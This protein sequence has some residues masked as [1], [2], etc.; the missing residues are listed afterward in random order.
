MPKGKR[1]LVSFFRF[2]CNFPAVWP[3]DLAS[4]LPVSQA[5]R[6]TLLLSRGKILSA[7]DVLLIRLQFSKKSI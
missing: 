3:S 1:I 5:E 6:L 4:V 7:V 2:Y